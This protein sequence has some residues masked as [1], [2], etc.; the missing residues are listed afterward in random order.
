MQTN[1]PPFLVTWE[2]NTAKLGKILL[3]KTDQSEGLP[4]DGNYLSRTSSISC[5]IHFQYYGDAT[6]FEPLFFSKE[7]S[8]WFT[9]NYTPGGTYYIF[10]FCGG[11][12]TKILAIN[13]PPWLW[14]FNPLQ[15]FKA[16]RYSFAIIAIFAAKILL[17]FLV[18]IDLAAIS[19]SLIKVLFGE[20][21]TY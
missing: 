7:L 20:P 18:L 19:F 11:P 2:T 8:C 6:T 15:A 14:D 16:F 3:V 4:G 17:T 12:A 1:L 10:F 9:Q 13:S 5:H 21:L